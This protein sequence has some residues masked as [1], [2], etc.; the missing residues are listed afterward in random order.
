MTKQKNI[1]KNVLKYYIYISIQTLYSVLCWSTFGSDY[2]LESSLVWRYKNGTPVFW[3]FLPFFSVDPLKRC[4][5]LYGELHC[6]AIFRSLQRCSI[7]FKSRL[8]VGHSRT[9]VDLSQSHSCVVLA[10]CLGSWTFAPVWGPEQVFIK[11]VS[12]LFSVH[13]SLNPDQSPSTLPLQNIPAAWWRH[14]HALP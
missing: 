10:V 12:A 1:Y 6:I 2:S 5:R 8:C 3:E 11:D 9:F 4:V 7:G 14:H 13:L